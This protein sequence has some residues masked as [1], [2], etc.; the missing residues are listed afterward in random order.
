M[1]PIVPSSAATVSGVVCETF[2]LF[3][4]RASSSC[5]LMSGCEPMPTPTTG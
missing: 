3:R 2:L 1:S 4:L 5:R